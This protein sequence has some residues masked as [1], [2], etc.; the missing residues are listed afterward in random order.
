MTLTELV[1]DDILWGYNPYKGYY[2]KGL[3][4]TLP[5]DEFEKL[6]FEI[7]CNHLSADGINIDEKL[8]KAE[9]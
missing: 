7:M 1:I 4:E 2:H 8:I 6:C 5:R 3:Y 9:G